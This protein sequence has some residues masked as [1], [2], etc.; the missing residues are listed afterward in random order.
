LR[1]LLNADSSKSVEELYQHKSKLEKDLLYVNYAINLRAIYPQ[2]KV[3]KLMISLVPEVKKP[4]VL[5]RSVSQPVDTIEEKIVEA[6]GG[7]EVSFDVEDD[8]E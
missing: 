3:L 8:E 7:V 5:L 1:P 6:V 4:D 2:L